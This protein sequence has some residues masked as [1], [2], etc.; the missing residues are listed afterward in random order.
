LLLIVPT[1][2]AATHQAGAFALLTVALFINH[3]LR[4]R[5]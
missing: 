1:V 3:E 5:P 4:S 2:L